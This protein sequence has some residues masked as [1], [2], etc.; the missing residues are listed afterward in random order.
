MGLNTKKYAAPRSRHFKGRG[1]Q[2]PDSL[3]ELLARYR[4]MQ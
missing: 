3:S 4:A 1:I 2:F